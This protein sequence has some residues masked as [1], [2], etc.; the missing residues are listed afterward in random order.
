MALERSPAQ[1]KIIVTPAKPADSRIAAGLIRLAMGKVA[2]F[3]FGFGSSTRATNMIEN[4]FTQNGSRFSYQL[5]H[6]ARTANGD[7][8]GIVIAYPCSKTVGLH[9]VMARQLLPIY[10]MLNSLL[11]LWNALVLLMGVLSFGQS[12]TCW[13]DEY[14]ISTLAVLPEFQGMGIGTM[15]L[16]YVE[17]EAKKA[18]FRKCSLGVDI[19][20][21]HAI[22]LYEH[23]GYKI[24]ETVKVKRFSKRIGSRGFYRMVKP[25]V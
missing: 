11:F 24:V 8:V 19:E 17:D 12:K 9:V 21:D 23:L 6:T 4:L 1:Q 7:I 18:G 2:D 22:R 5:A 13:G 20:N 15:L 14:Y 16:A 3:M 25:L 10:G